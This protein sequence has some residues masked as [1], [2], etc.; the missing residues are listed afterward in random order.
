[1]ETVHTEIE[2]PAG[3]RRVVIAPRSEDLAAPDGAGAVRVSAK[4]SGRK[5]A[6]T[7]ELSARPSVVAP[8]DYG[9]LLSVE[10]SLENESSRLLLL[11]H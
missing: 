4:A 3:F 2:L 6:V 11:E 7:Q 8:E 5:W 1:M 10:S 9:A